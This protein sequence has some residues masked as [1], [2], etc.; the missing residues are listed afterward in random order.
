MV[1]EYQTVTGAMTVKFRGQE[2]TLP[3]MRKFLLEPDRALREDA[4]RATARRR[5]E[6]KD[7]LEELFERMFALRD[8]IAANAGFANYRDYIWRE[9]HRFDYTP[10]DCRKF[11]D[12]V[13]K[14]VVPVLEEMKARRREEM[15]IEAVKP[16]DIDVDSKGRAALKPFESV[17]EFKA[18]VLKVFES[19]EP[20][21]G[22]EF[23]EMTE[24]GL[25]DLPSRKGK[26]PGG[27]QST[28]WEARKPFIF[29][30]AVGTQQDVGTLVHEGG[31]SFHSYA[32]AGQPIM[33]YRHSPLEF[34]EVASMGME[35]LAG[36]KLGVFYDEEE[37]ARCRR[38]QLEHI[39]AILAWIATIDSFQHWMYENRG[40]SRQERARKWVEIDE[41][42]GSQMADWSG[43]EEEHAYMWHRQLHIFQVPFYYIE[44]G[45]AQIGALQLWVQSKKDFR[46]A[47]ENYRKALKL[48]GSRP[49][50]Q[51]FAAAGLKFDLSE[52]VLGPLME[53]I[54][55][56][57]ANMN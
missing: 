53:E 44:Y 22:K 16:W 54:D 12:A 43:L 34:A 23:K 2:Y 15:K 47:V 30:N 56:E 55:N 26:A 6:E 25:V 42:F 57:L 14:L 8:K 19:I 18:K 10:A 38:E 29:M 1:Q 21:F 35:L 5:L 39:V 32:S 7:K 28:L 40:H 17:E 36:N 51:L 24:L 52:E 9:Y 4:W 37:L 48:G 41:R 33:A 20:E 50:P 31:H 13:E 46:G 49:L 27:Y 45:I 11:H 3:Q